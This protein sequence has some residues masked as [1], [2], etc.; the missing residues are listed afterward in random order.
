[1][2]THRARPKILITISIDRKTLDR[3]KFWKKQFLENQSK[4]LQKLL[5]ALNF[6]DEMHEYEMKC[7]SKTLVWNPVF[8]K[9]RFSNNSP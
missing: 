2:E 9:L 5:K 3:S 1:M 7:F 6:M 8:L 4:I